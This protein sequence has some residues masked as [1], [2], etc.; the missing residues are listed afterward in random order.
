[1][2]T[3]AV[4][5]SEGRMGR[6]VRGEA[7]IDGGFQ[8]AACFDNSG[9]CL[10]PGSPLP[11]QVDVVID[12]STPSAMAALENTLSGSGAALV[13]GTTGLSSREKLMLES[14]STTRAVFYS[15]NMSL[16]V[17]VL[18]RLVAEAARMAGTRFDLEIAEFH[19]RD[20]VDSPSGTAL[21][22]LESWKAGLGRDLS[23]VYGREGAVGPRRPG[24]AGLHSIRGG[25]VAGDHEVHLLG[26]GERLLLAHRASGR[27]TFALGALAAARFAAGR[28]PGLYGMDDLMSGGAAGL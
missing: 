17:Y 15:A 11:G 16:G 6:A 7:L 22:L 14:W 24:E 10:E 28:P 8:V 27:R 19:H 1:V 20:K 5:G 26:D 13:S 21:R 3:L 18:A 12:F 9:G 25:D 23:T 4:F 2:I